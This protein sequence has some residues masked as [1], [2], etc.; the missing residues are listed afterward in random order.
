[1]RLDVLLSKKLDLSRSR[2]KDLMQNNKIKIKNFKTLKPSEELEWEDISI[3]D[4]IIDQDDIE[5]VG[6]GKDKLDFAINH[7]NIDVNNK[8]CLDIGCSTGGFTQTLLNYNAKLIY[9]VDVGT[10]QFSNILKN[11]SKVKLYENT[12]IRYFKPNIMFDIIVCDVSFISSRL[13]AQKINELLIDNFILL[14]KPQFEL[15]KSML[16][17]KGIVKKNNYVDMAVKN[18]ID[19]YK[20]F[21]I[22]CKDFVQSPIKGKSGNTEFLAFFKK[23]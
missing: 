13:L 20:T 8:I 15:E 1:M 18:V 11:N 9:S 22:I 3:E 4:I 21:D 5:K 19:H 14:I 2:I 10:A 7:F 16:N 23:E 12:D 6:R 17:K